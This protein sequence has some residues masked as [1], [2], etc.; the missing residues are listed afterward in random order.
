MIW[1]GLRGEVGALHALWRHVARDE[2]FDK[3]FT[4]W[5]ITSPIL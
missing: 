4:L 2:G 1:G 5:Y 3:Q